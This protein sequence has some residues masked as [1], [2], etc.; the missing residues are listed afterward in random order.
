MK[1]TIPTTALCS[2]LAVFAVAGCGSSKSS[3]SDTGAAAT[4]PPTTAPS[5]GSSGG[6]SSNLQLSADPSGQLK[7]DKK[8]LSTKAGN[9]T[10]TMTNPSPVPH[11]IAVEGNGVDKDGKTVSSN[12]KSTVTVSLK[13]GK[14]TFYCPVDGHRA[15]GMQG[16]LT[17][18]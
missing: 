2:A 16:T 13:P 3:S 12:G 8:T 5:G 15:A 1:R 17:V 4:P 6:A 14:Y 18:K 7:F 10:V 9:V 11:A